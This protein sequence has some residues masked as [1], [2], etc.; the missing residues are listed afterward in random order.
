[1]SLILKRLM[2]FGG[3]QMI[4][5]RRSAWV[6]ALFVL[7]AL[8]L[9]ACGNAQPKLTLVVAGSA[10]LQYKGEWAFPN[11]GGSV[12]GAIL[13]EDG[14][15]TVYELKSPVLYLNFQKQADEG[16]MR[17]EI[18]EGDAVIVRLETQAPYGAVTLGTPTEFWPTPPP[19]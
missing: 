5:W 8:V 3:G 18:R 4:T 12:D 13:S 16:W 10:G 15:P 2:V 9:A 17:V 6:L 11:E 14:T 7:G 1:M 19:Q